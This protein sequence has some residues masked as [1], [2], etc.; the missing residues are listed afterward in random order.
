MLLKPV[1][2]EIDHNVERPGFLEQMGGSGND[3]QSLLTGKFRERGAV[4][5]KHGVVKC[6]DD[7]QGGGVD[8]V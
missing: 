7:Q 8:K 6:A 1:P 2:A 4:D 5:F 3:L